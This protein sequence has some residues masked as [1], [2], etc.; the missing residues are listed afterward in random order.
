MIQYILG[1]YTYLK[2][3]AIF[4]H[5]I[6]IRASELSLILKILWYQNSVCQITKHKML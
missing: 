5:F 2:H 1:L 6:F 3:L 4:K